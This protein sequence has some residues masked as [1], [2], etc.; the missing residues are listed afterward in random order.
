MIKNLVKCIGEYKKYAIIAPIFVIGEMAAE[1]II[2]FLTSNLIDY[3]ID[4]GDMNYIIKSGIYILICTILSIIFGCIAGSFS[5]K[6]SAGFAKNVREKMYENVQ[7]FSFSN[8]DKYS[9]SSII[10]RLTTDV[11]NIQN[12]FQM[13]AFVA[14]VAPALLILSTVFAF[15]I[16]VE[17]AL[18][19]LACV[20]LLAVA[21]YFTASSAHPIFTKVF[22]IYDKLNESVE[23]NLNGI[24]VVKSFVRE[25][26]EKRKFFKI[27][28]VIYKYFL[29]GEKIIAFNMPLMQFSMYVCTILAAWF[30][31]RMIV[32]GRNDPANGL[33]TGQ[34]LSLI[35]YSSQILMGLMI[36]AMILTF[37]VISISSARRI[38]EILTEKSDIT[39]PKNAIEDVENG[40]ISFKNVGFSYVKDKYKLCLKDINLDINSGEMIGITGGTGSGKSTLVHMIPRLYDAT[41]GEVFVGG[42]NVKNY[43]LKTLRN[44]VAMV[45]QKNTLFSGTIKENLRWGNENATDDEMKRACK[46][47]QADE[48]INNMPLKYDTY[49]KR[50]GSNL[51]GGQKQRICIARALLK[52]PKI[53]I[54]DDST[55]AVDTKTDALI[56]H[57]FKNYLPDTT[58]IIISQRI[59]SIKHADKIIVIENGH[60]IGFD[61]HEN[62]IKSC[63]LYKQTYELQMK[64]G[65]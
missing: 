35:A 1:V 6:A 4:K 57:S 9:T 53:L 60:V 43:D 21:L 25:E 62:L 8:I 48:F 51:S 41:L 29:S 10:T 32:A 42:V 23:E 36:L 30:G 45:L 59:S 49:I 39:S 2:P 34:L 47:A 63:E 26:H 58:K 14:P 56:R 65:K 46:I 22:K 16:N 61:T 27:S 3:G 20:P 13:L 64:G 17:L 52:N 40:K 15:R 33:T 19:F 44:A 5:A 18:L 11:T 12:A 28:S 37:I 24:R 55:S 7:N 54:L 31:A 38:Y 50:E